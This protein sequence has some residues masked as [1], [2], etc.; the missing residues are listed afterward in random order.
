MKVLPR[1]NI[2]LAL[3]SLVLSAF[4]WLHVQSLQELKVSRTVTLRLVPINLD[5]SRYVIRIPE[6]VQILANGPLDAHEQLKELLRS[7]R[8]TG[9]VATADLSDARPEM[10]SYRVRVQGSDQI[11]RLGLELSEV[12]DVSVSIQEVLTKVIPIKAIPTNVPDGF[13][14][15]EAQIQP[16]SVTIRGAENDLARVDQVRV[17]LDL[18]GYTPG[19]KVTQTVEVLDAKL[20]PMTAPQISVTP[21]EVEITPSLAVAPP[22]R[23]LF[24]SVSFA[25]GTKP[26]PG[27]RFTGYSVRPLTIM[28]KGNSSVLQRVQSVSTEPISLAGLRTRTTK[29]VRL[30]ALKDIGL[31]TERVQV[32]LEIEPIQAV[33]N[34]APINPAPTNP[35][36]EKTIN[37]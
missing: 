13:A 31:L 25:A 32:T 35:P 18:E 34:P 26:A 23:S 6:T 9:I 5:E 28:A 19:K 37:P 36:S 24:V 15:S 12:P 8:G 17:L 11:S 14:F 1:V 4:V 27:Y 30:V 7:A 3:A 21:S 10:S 29:T 16:P 20:K 33:E 2:G 22:Q